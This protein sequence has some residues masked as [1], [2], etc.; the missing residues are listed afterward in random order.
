MFPCLWRCMGPTCP[1]CVGRSQHT[2]DDKDGPLGWSSATLHTWHKH[3]DITHT[4]LSNTARS[5]FHASVSSVGHK[6]LRGT[7]VLCCTCQLPD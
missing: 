5:S 4:T 1:A 7:Q 2:P 6:R 3:G